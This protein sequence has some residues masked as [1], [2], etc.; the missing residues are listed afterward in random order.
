[1]GCTNFCKPPKINSK[2][3][4]FVV[5]H[6]EFCATNMKKLQYHN[7]ISSSNPFYNQHVCPL[8]VQSEGRPFLCLIVATCNKHN[9]CFQE[10]EVED[11]INEDEGLRM[12]SK[13]KREGLSEDDDD[14]DWEEGQVS[15]C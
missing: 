6:S 9:G 1:M 12:R 4:P 5:L 15:L 7:F 8:F 14:G 2:Y 13:I 3:P 11:N 10:F